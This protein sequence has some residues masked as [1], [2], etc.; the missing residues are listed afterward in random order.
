MKTVLLVWGALLA[1]PL[2]G[3]LVT[4]MIAFPNFGGM[5]LWVVGLC[6]LMVYADRKR[7]RDRKR[8][9]ASGRPPSGG[10]G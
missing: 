2:L 10:E 6:G 4:L 5:M 3:L 7:V 8:A 1:L 9:Q